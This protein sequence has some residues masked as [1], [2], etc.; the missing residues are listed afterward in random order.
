MSINFITNHFLKKVISLH[1][2]LNKFSYGIPIDGKIVDICDPAEFFEKYHYLSPEEFLR[3]KGG[4]CW[5]YAQYQYEILSRMAPNNNGIKIFNVYIELINKDEAT[6]TFTVIKT[7]DQEKRYVYIESSFRRIQ[8]VY[9]TNRISHIIN[10]VVQNMLADYPNINTGYEV[11]I[12]KGYDNYGC[13]TVEFMNYMRSQKLFISGCQRYGELKDNLRM[14]HESMEDLENTSFIFLEE[15]EEDLIYMEEAIAH[16]FH[17]QKLVWERIENTL[18]KPENKRKYQRIQNEFI[19]RNMAKLTTP[20][21][22]YLIVFGDSD[23]NLYHEL[24]GITREEIIQVMIQITKKTGSNSDFKF[25]RQNPVLV[26]L[27]FCIRYFTLKKDK[28]SLNSTLGIYTL[29]NYWSAFTKYFPK[30]VIAPVMEYTIDHMSDKFSIKKAGSIFNVL[31]QS[32]TQSYTFHTNR[33]IHG[34]DFEVVSFLQ[35][36]R[37][38]QNSLIKKI[39]NEYMKNWAEG[40]AITTRNDNYDPDNPILDDVESVSTVVQ[41]KVAKVTLPIISNGVDLVF[42][43]AAAKMAGISVSDCRQYLIKIMIP[44]NL[45]ALEEFI[46]AILYIFISTD[47]RNVSHIKSQY[48]LAWAASLFKKTNSKDPNLRK[49]N[50]TLEKWAE[51]SGIYERFRREASRINYKKGIFFYVIL[52]I[53]KY[54]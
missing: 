6:H 38:D 34:D 42:A 32:I 24:F 49:I 21:P 29:A 1:M 48:F 19:E 50:M 20:G 28:Q 26:I 3:A 36:I 10:F 35:R 8:G 41:A 33:I 9:I 17:L 39:A 7:E 15:G 44:K 46:E 4:V 2:K 37:N 12:Y 11:R 40:N 51:E 5:D 47:G 27:Y 45:N 43:E 23:Q 52:S 22:Q 31:M 53:Q 30:G 18:E 54:A 16:E 14:I 13:N 25:L